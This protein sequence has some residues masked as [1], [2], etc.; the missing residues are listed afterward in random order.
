MRSRRSRREGS[1]GSGTTMSDVARH[2][3]VSSQTVSRVIG[4]PGLVAEETRRRVEEA[5]R[6]L[7]YIPNGAARNLASNSGSVVAV[8]IPTLSSSAFAAQVNGVVERLVERGISVVVGNTE[9]SLAREEEIIRGLLER[10]P[11]GFVLTGV[12]HSQRALALLK[13][14]HVPVVET[15]D[16][17]KRALDMAVGFSNLGAGYDVGRMLVVRGSRR[18]AFVGGVPAQDPRAQSRF[19]GLCRALE[20][21]GLPA[22]F[23]VE[24]DL[25]MTSADGIVGLDR[26]LERAP[27]TD[28][29]F[30][31]ADTLALSA[32]LECNRR[33]IRVPEQLAICGFGDY[34]LAALVT[35]SLTTVRTLPEM[36]GRQAAEMLL[37]QIDGNAPQSRSITLQHQLIRRGSA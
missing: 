5:I 24:L 29:V 2:A 30:F 21:A 4:K 7:D 15:W 8:I 32:V 6:R 27:M 19:L 13:Q 28:A 17:D 25:P 1:E 22:P 34:D 3:G 11:I 10:R 23:R 18:V 20:E 33:G 14:S 12:E 16:T 37:A 26:I 35:P 36:M 31:S 9:Y